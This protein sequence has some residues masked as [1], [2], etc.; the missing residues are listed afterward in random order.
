MQQQMFDAVTL[1]RSKHQNATLA[2]V[3]YSLGAA[4]ATFAA[5]DL[6]NHYPQDKFSF[7]SFG[8]PRTGND[9]FADYVMSLFPDTAYARVVHFTD[10]V[11]HL[12][13]EAMEFKHAGMEIW[14][15]NDGFDMAHKICHNQIG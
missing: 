1:H 6:K 2:V 15:Y 3:G 9:K 5:V 11:P 7:Y 13:L 12:P 10:A 14:Y 4:L 8:S